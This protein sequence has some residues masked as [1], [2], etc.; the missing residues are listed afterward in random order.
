MNLEFCKNLESL[1][2][3]ESK[4]CNGGSVLSNIEKKWFPPI[5]LPVPTPDGDNRL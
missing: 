5:I 4:N 1:K 2:E 3:E